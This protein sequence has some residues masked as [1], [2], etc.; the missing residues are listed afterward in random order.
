MTAGK[1]SGA[2]VHAFSLRCL[3]TSGHAQIRGG[4]SQ[5]IVAKCEKKLQLFLWVTRRFHKGGS[6]IRS[7]PRNSRS[8]FFYQEEPAPPFAFFSGFL[9][10]SCC[11]HGA[12]CCDLLQTCSWF[13]A[14]IPQ[15]CC[16]CSHAAV[17]KEGH[18]Q[19]N[20]PRDSTTNAWNK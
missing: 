10:P 12:A 4:C 16:M 3:V 14:D 7:P 13:E 19:G 2:N 6:N 17:I 18:T 11:I 20:K 5:N 9:C 8:Q 15:I 1:A